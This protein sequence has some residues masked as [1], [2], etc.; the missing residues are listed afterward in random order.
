M[1][2]ACGSKWTE[3]KADGGDV[4]RRAVDVVASH[5]KLIVAWLKE[6]RETTSTV[7]QAPQTKAGTDSG[8]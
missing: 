7:D 1:I 4:M 2:G 3:S 6:M 5:L 8:W